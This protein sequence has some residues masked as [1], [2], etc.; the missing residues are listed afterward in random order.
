LLLLSS[1]LGVVTPLLL[2][3]TLNRLPIV[4]YQQAIINCTPAA[5]A[6]AA[7][8]TT[9]VDRDSRAFL[10]LCSL[11]YVGIAV[12]IEGYEYHDRIT[13]RL[14]LGVWC[15]PPCHQRG[16]DLKRANLPCF[17]SCLWFAKPS[18][19]SCLPLADSVVVV[20]VGITVVVVVVVAELLYCST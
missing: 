10:T 9:I 1:V 5:A 17:F 6:A 2:A 16:T 12:V 15:C 14:P 3:S 13:Y 20:A 7:A 18:R 8:T 11:P 4:P 19:S